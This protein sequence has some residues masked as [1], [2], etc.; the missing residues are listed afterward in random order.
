MRIFGHGFECL[1]E[2]SSRELLSLEREGAIYQEQ[3]IDEIQDIRFVRIAFAPDEIHEYVRS[4]WAYELFLR[5]GSPA[6]ASDVPGIPED[7]A[8]R[9]DA[10]QLHAVDG[11]TV[12]PPYHCVAGFIGEELE[13]LVCST[14]QSRRV[15]LEEQG[16]AALITTVKRVVDALTPTIRHFS[17]RE[18]GLKPWPVEREKDVRDLMYAM[19]RAAIHDIQLEEP[20]PSKGGVWKVVD[21]FSATAKLFVEVKW[22][23]KSGR[24]KQVLD[25]VSVDIQAYGIHPACD[26]IVFLIVDAVKD[27]PD[28]ALV[29]GDFSNTQ[30]IDGKEIRILLFVREP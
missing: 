6:G 19:L 3:W 15:I 7:I 27:I 25:E 4:L 24:W 1:L 28:P 13:E 30:V 11:K 2:Y 14:P 8:K 12:G 5:A 10:Y 29:E 9:A 26:T 22:I 20:I 21:I 23:G 17:R 16:T 18:K